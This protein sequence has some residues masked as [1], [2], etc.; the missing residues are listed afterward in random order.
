MIEKLIS[1]GQL[2]MTA[3]AGEGEMET[4]S[5]SSTK[6][7]VPGGKSEAFIHPSYTPEAPQRK[8][9][10][11]AN[12]KALEATEIPLRFNKWVRRPN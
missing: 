11:A 8:P 12:D 3:P 6:N 1:G 9:V 7:L 5:P 4:G 2:V 10:F